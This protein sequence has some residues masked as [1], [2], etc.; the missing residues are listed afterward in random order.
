[1]RTYGINLRLA[2]SIMEEL[3][4]ARALSVAIL[5]RSGDVAGVM[6]LP[7]PNPVD[8]DNIERYFCD[9]QASDLFRKLQVN[10]PSIDRRSPTISKWWQGE[11]QCYRS[12]ERL[13]KFENRSNLS[14]PSEL[15]VFDFLSKVRKTITSWVGSKP[16]FPR[17]DPRKVRSRVYLL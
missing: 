5:L 9:R 16:P 15:A 3:G 14:D 11:R 4:T 10:L 13:A 2:L 8:Y 6:S 12:N 7:T 1:M 17:F